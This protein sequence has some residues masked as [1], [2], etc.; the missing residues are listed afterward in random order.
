MSLPT[1][2]EVGQ[3]LA[4]LGNYRVIRVQEK[5]YLLQNKSWKP[6]AAS[7]VLA[8][9][10]RESTLRNVCGG[11]VQN[12]SGEWVK[13]YSD[14]G[15]VQIADTIDTNAKWLAKQEGCAE[16]KWTPAEPPV[17]ALEPRHCPRFTV[18]LEYALKEL[19]GD[20]AFGKKEGVSDPVRFAVAAYN[21]GAG[22]ALRG[23][24]AGDVDKYT[25]HGDY[26]KSVLEIQPLI[27]DWIVAH[28]NWQYKTT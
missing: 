24:R 22:G 2:F 28:P 8:L 7:L 5:V 14:R 23:Y 20:Y 10:F 19:K 13:S 11:A 21:G 25:A 1:T 27:H 26:S 6:F 4:N 15:W 16:G 12:E 3:A 17:S 18:A 9:G